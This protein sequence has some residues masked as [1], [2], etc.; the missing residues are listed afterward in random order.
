MEGEF[1]VKR[2]AFGIGTGEW[3]AT[4]VIGADVKIRFNVRLH[5]SA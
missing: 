1:V 2:G 4:R 3:A 5:K